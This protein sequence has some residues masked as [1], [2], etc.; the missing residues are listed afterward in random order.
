MREKIYRRKAEYFL[1][2][3]ALLQMFLGVRVVL[4]L[5]RSM[6]GEQIS[7]SE[8]ATLAEEDKE[9]VTVIIPVLNEYHRLSPCLHGL[10]MQGRAI[11]EIVVVDG[12]SYDGT[13]ELVHTYEQQDPRVHLVDASPVPSDWNG[14]AWGL[15]VGLRSACPDTLWILTMDADV[16]PQA[17]L[18]Q[19]LLTRAK[20]EG[21]AAL[22]IATLQEIHGIGEGLLHP[23]FLTTL[24]YRFGIPGKIAHRVSEVQANGQCF[25]FFREAL[26][27]CAGFADARHSLCEDVTMARSLVARGYSFG[28]YEVGELAMVRM[29]QDWRDTWNNWARSLPMHDHFSGMS[30]LSGYLE[31]ALI[32]ALPLPLFLSLVIG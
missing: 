5:L 9:S 30:T 6:G 1:N 21:L 2:Y 32:Q 7:T 18:V 25:L 10:M 20:R 3:F 28:F 19:A 31:I 26:E 27:T 24:V 15:Q 12:G 4:R 8:G 13:Q 23:S 11:A 14:K 29:Y 17:H 22:S 16:R